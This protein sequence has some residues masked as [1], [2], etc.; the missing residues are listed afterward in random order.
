MG[1]ALVEFVMEVEDAF[2]IKI[3]D[4]EAGAIST[5][6]ELVEYL[7]TRLPNDVTGVCLT[8]RA[9]GRI[10]DAIVRV[11]GHPPSAIRRETRWVDLIPPKHRRGTWRLLH[12]AAKPM[13][14]PKLTLLGAFGRELS[15]VGAVARYVAAQ[16]PASLKKPD[17]G[18]TKAEVKEVI[19]SLMKLQFGLDQ[20][21]W[22]Q[23]FVEDLRMD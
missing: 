13:R 12:V 20:F 16:D 19:R 7:L 3:P 17:V 6:G 18:W 11:L 2:D 8:Q 1:L 9:F 10:R 15:T 21:G 22:D 14:W 4:R 5:P 23:R